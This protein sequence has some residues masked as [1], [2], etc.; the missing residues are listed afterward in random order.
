MEVILLGFLVFVIVCFILVQIFDF[1]MS[2]LEKRDHKDIYPLT[3]QE[4]IQ[5][6]RQRNLDK[7]IK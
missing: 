6:K 4:E 5:I 3:K 2:K 1:A 7:L